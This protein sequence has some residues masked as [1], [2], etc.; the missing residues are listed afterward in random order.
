LVGLSA[1]VLM[2]ATEFSTIQSVRIG[3]SSCGA[4]EQGVRDICETS[5]AEQ[6]H[7]ALLL[8]ALLTAFLSFGAAVGRSKP[9]AIALIGAG[10]A[11]LVIA[12][13]IDHGSLSDKHGLDARYSQVDPVTGGGYT[14]ERL[15]GILAIAAGGLALI[16]DAD[17]L[18]LPS[19]RLPR[20][21]RSSG[22]SDDDGDGQLTLDEEE[23][24]EARRAEREAKRSTAEK[25]AA[26]AEPE[27]E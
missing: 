26:D 2:A 10:V 15:A 12:F 20:R 19:P 18:S 17:G 16:L 27:P 11:V 25:P 1:A 8:L 4:A 13:A 6:H 5:G 21:T 3:E 23:E 14:L 22:P 9:A 24:R 7:Y